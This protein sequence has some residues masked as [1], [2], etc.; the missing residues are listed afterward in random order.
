MLI[1]SQPIKADV[2]F[3]HGILGAAFKTWRQ[4]DRIVAEEK[5]EADSTDDYTECWP[6]VKNLTNPSFNYCGVLWITKKC[7]SMFLLLQWNEIF[8]KTIDIGHFSLLFIYC[9]LFY[10]QSWLAADCPNLRVLSVE[11]DSHLSDWMA[12]C[13]AENQRWGICSF[14]TSIGV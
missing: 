7:L 11:Y 14:Y 10:W 6:K 8:G 1:S 12:K 4:K 13:P 3:I 5:K 9:V 2:L